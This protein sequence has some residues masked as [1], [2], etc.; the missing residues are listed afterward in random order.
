MGK[1]GLKYL[2]LVGI[3]VLYLPL[4]L[5]VFYYVSFDK[6]NYPDPV[7]VADMNA[8]RHF[9]G[10]AFPANTRLVEGYAWEPWLFAAKLEIAKNDLPQFLAQH[11]FQRLVERDEESNI[12]E[13]RC[14]TQKEERAKI[15]R[16]KLR[17]YRHSLLLRRSDGCIRLRLRVGWPL[18]DVGSYCGY[19]S[20]LIGLDDPNVATVYLSWDCRGGFA[21]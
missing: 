4:L 6:V 5:G 17:G 7:A 8:V 13:D 2:R 16:W 1:H 12:F 9:T 18:K 11:G 20:F 21:C 19:I 15:A 3:C 14:A 10:L